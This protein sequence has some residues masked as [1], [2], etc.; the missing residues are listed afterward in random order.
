METSTKSVRKVCTLYVIRFA[1][2]VLTKANVEQRT[3]FYIFGQKFV[4]FPDWSINDDKI[5]EVV[6]CN[7][8]FRACY[9]Y[10][11]LV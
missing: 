2:Y 1:R 11:K 6:N 3:E 5:Y 9:K 10:N 4:Y 8:F 7:Y